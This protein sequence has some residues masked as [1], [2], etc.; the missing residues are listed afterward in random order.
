VLVA[1]LAP[2]GVVVG[3]QA[4]PAA[5]G[6]TP[7]LAEAIPIR[8]AV[9][10][11]LAVLGEAWRLD[12]LADG[13]RPWLEDE[14]SRLV[15]RY[16][17]AADLVAGANRL[18]APSLGRSF[19][20]AEVSLWSAGGD[21]LESRLDDL[22]TKVVRTP[23]RITAGLT[24]PLERSRGAGLASYREALLVVALPSDRHLA[25]RLFAHEL[26]HLF[27]AVHLPGEGILMAPSVPGDALDPL[28]VRLLQ[29]HCDRRLDP[30]LFPLPPGAL[31]AARNAYR[32]AASRTG[33]ADALLAQVALEQ[34]DAEAAL[35]VAS[36][37]LGRDPG[38]VDAHLVRGIALRRLERTAEAVTEY[39]WVRERRPSYAAV[40]YDLAIALDHLGR[41]DEALAAYE[42]AVELDP[43]NASAF[44]N[45]ARLLARRG[46]ADRALAAARRALE[47]APDFAG[48]RVNLAMAYLA[49]GET[50][51]AEAAARQAV[52]ER[53]DLADAHEA[54]GA[55][56]LAGG[57]PE[58]AA[59]AFQKAS[60]L[61]P[62]EPRFRDQEAVAL[63]SLARLRRRAGD[64]DG[65][66]AAL[67]RAT[68]VAPADAEAWS[69][70]A[71]LAF[72]RGRRAEAREAY[73]RRLALRP[74]DAAAHNNLAVVLF[75]SGDVSGARR[76]VEAAQRLG[77]AVHPDFLEALAAAEAR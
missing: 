76:H 74:D 69:E 56:L 53:Q 12:G 60:A 25:A 49:A 8:F 63:R 18:L 40:H 39:E 71:D 35:E 19:A 33:E 10:T 4:R 14:P 15:A 28:T 27:G 46:A 61:K 3:S 55:A 36:R 9:D 7:P 42:R 68:R 38:D 23:G 52:A 73:T 44:S 47:L 34:G 48:A 37:A 30:H 29:L 1:A 67:E 6:E 20:L 75:R 66:Q 24:G 51:P 58:D 77:L 50:A 41:S 31:E 13:S 21:S 62:E 11:R 32:E 26:A 72:E 2:D 54:L 64:L 70:R 43:A 5:A 57:R 65:A 17:L 22:R 16:R 45:L 59:A